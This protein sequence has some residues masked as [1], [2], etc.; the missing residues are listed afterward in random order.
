MIRSKIDTTELQDDL[1][2]HQKWEKIVGM[3]SFNPDKESPTG[4]TSSEPLTPS[5]HK[6]FR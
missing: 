1:D 4:V 6:F 5:M 2:R 3:M